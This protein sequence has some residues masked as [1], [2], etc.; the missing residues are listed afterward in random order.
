VYHFD[1]VLFDINCAKDKI[2]F[3]DKVLAYSVRAMEAFD[4]Q[5]LA[6]I[7]IFIGVFAKD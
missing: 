5:V 6:L 1:L 4:L 7:L 2:I 3:T